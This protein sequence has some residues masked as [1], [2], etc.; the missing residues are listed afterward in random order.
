MGHSFDPTK[1]RPP[2]DF[3]F[4][5]SLPDRIP[6]IT[7]LNENYCYKSP[8]V[9]GQHQ[10]KAARFVLLRSYPPLPTNFLAFRALR[11][12]LLQNEKK[13]RTKKTGL[14]PNPSCHLPYALRENLSRLGVSRK[15]SGF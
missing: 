13:K 3:P 1:S 15:I 11:L 6:G 12:L 2:I 9:T 5:S 7:E 8:P 14:L 4:S 10:P